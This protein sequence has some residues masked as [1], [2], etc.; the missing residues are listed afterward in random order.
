[1]KGLLKLLRLKP[2]IR[3]GVSEGFAE[4]TEVETGN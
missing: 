2:E 4:V 3:L 1:M